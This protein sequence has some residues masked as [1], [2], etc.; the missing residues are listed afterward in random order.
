[1]GM[2]G[3]TTVKA[4]VCGKTTVA[5]A[6]FDE[7]SGLCTLHIITDCPHF[8]KVADKLEGR[9]VK[10]AEEFAWETST[11][12][13]AMRANCSHT[14]CPVPSGMLKAVQVACGKKPAANADIMVK[15]E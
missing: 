4:G 8:Q 5:S 6:E 7:K 10:P 11:I 1:M 12:H 14:A 9:A 2:K 15:S 3:I 13:A